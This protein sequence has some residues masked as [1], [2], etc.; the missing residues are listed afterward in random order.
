MLEKCLTWLEYQPEA[1]D[2]NVC[3]LRQLCTLA[4]RKRIQSLKQRT[5]ICYQVLQMIVVTF[6]IVFNSV[7]CMY[8]Y[9]MNTLNVYT[10]YMYSVIRIFHIYEQIFLAVDQRGWIT[11]DALYMTCTIMALVKHIEA[12]GHFFATDM[13]T[14]PTTHSDTPSLQDLV[15][16]MQMTTNDRPDPCA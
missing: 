9:N 8:M 5:L 13:F 4:A 2:Y 6:K 15:I 1:N 14:M 3:T 11:E 16:F 7:M 12:N 10:M